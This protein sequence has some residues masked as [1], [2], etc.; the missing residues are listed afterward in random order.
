M[1]DTGGNP[2]SLLSYDEKFAL[3]PEGL[4]GAAGSEGAAC[5]PG[6][7]QGAEITPA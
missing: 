6:G 5:V 1:R 7:S 4:I 2:W 3:I